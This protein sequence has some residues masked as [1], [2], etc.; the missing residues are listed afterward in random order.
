MINKLMVRSRIRCPKIQVNIYRSR[1]SVNI[2]GVG[3]GD[4][5]DIIPVNVQ[6]NSAHVNGKSKLRI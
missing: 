5:E 2:R 3:G 6:L 1:A 4:K